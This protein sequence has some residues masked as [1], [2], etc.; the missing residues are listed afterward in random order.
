MNGHITARG[1]EQS[2]G[3]DSFWE[4]VDRKLSEIRY[5]ANYDPVQILMYVFMLPA[6]FSFTLVCSHPCTQQRVEVY[7]HRGPVRVQ[8]CRSRLRLDSR[9]SQ[10]VR[11]QCLP[12]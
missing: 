1:S 2:L 12:A 3:W 9:V 7:S 6:C 10:D 8:V 4:Y 11:S 5:D